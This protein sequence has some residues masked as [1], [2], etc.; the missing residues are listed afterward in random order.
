MAVKRTGTVIVTGGISKEVSVTVAGISK[1][2]I[3][4]II[5]STIHKGSFDLE[6]MG[7][8]LY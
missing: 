3:I 6:A 2:I 7:E 4:I 8:R 5:I 1:K